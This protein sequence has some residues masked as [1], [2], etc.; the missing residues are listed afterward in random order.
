MK[1]ARVLTVACLSA[2]VGEAAVAAPTDI[3]IDDQ[4]VFPESL[5]STPDGTLYIGG[6][7]TGRIYIA[8]PGQETFI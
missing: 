2:I 1:Y 7:G 5:G 4:K 8:K 6:S 3:V